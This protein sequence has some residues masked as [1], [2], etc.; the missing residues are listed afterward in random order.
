MKHA[1]QV[2]FVCSGNICRSP[3]AE[4]VFRARV[5]EAGL[6][7]FVNVDSAGTHA[8]HEDESADPRTVR[9][10]QEHDYRTDRPHRA[11]RFTSDWFADRDLVIALDEG[12][13]RFLRRLA[14][15]PEDRAK[16]HLLLSYLPDAAVNP[17]GLGAQEVPDP[18]FGGAD[19]FADCLRAVQPACVGLLEAVRNATEL[20][21]ALPSG[22]A[23]RATDAA[24][25]TS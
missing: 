24:E 6:G 20:R 8:Y 12:H 11:R 19:G 17:F 2:T 18:Y 23:G 3:M 1:Y 15:G 10:L 5:E 16:V 4:T 22:P 13:L 21:E 7:D 9:V 25:P 14:R